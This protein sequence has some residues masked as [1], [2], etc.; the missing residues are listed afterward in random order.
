MVGIWRVGRLIPPVRHFGRGG[1]PNSNTANLPEV[2]GIIQIVY[3]EIF[4][5][6]L[7]FAPLLEA[8]MFKL[9]PFGRRVGGEIHT[10]RV[11]GACCPNT[12]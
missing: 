7:R 11:A 2:L 5:D 10:L 6:A 3:F 8:G 1:A 4:L 9:V 12:D